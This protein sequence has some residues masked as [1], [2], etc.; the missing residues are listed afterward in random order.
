MYNIATPNL[1]IYTV[2]YKKLTKT[3]KCAQGPLLS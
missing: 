2:F 1:Q 3:E